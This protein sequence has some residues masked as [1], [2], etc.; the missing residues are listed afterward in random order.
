M[1]TTVWLSYKHVVFGILFVLAMI[2]D[3][4]NSPIGDI[5]YNKNKWQIYTYYIKSVKF[6]YNLYLIFKIIKL[7][8]KQTFFD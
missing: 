3:K 6:G 8:F 1:Y 5:I 4:S 7:I 2:E